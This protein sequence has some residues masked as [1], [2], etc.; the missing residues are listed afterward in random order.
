M[1][2]ILWTEMLVIFMN[3]QFIIRFYSTAT[4]VCNKEKQ[5]TLTTDF[6]TIAIARKCGTQ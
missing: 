4:A 1:K 3:R 6:E 2:N 5:L